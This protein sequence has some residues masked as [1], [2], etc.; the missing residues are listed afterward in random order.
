MQKGIAASQRRRSRRLWF[1][2]LFVVCSVL[3]IRGLECT[4]LKWQF[5]TT[6]F[7]EVPV[8]YGED[9]HDIGLLVCYDVL[10]LF[11][12]LRRNEFVQILC[13]SV[14]GSAM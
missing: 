10:F 12:C 14:S 9:H 1:L 6:P 13:S 8:F 2:L 11:V 5:Y 7:F 4:V 3:S